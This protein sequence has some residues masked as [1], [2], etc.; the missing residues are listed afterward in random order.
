MQTRDEIRTQVQRDVR[1]AVQQAREAAREAARD[2]REA[3]REAR[4][5]A[6]AEANIAAQGGA[7]AVLAQTTPVDGNFMLEVLRGE[8]SSTRDFINALNARLEDTP[9]GPAHQVITRQIEQA[10]ER[11]NVLQSRLDGVL[12]GVSPELVTS[13][14]SSDFP[15]GLNGDTIR[16]IA[17]DAT[18]SAFVLI[19]ALAIGIPLIRAFSRW[20]DRRNQ[21]VPTGDFAH[22]L[23]RIEQAIDS[24]ALEVERV[25]ESQR[26][27][28][29]VLN[30]IRA[31]PAPDPMAAWPAAPA[32][33][34]ISVRTS[35]TE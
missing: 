19:F 25:S 35:T 14:E 20:L 33:E 26:Y 10:T 9:P 2:A 17:R 22:R 34:Q 27:N 28:A 12:T 29:R 13:T 15:P 1:E 7:A 16:E 5:E 18:R 30:E 8:L 3:A 4:A 32:R 11:L 6:A 24:V 23:D 21:P 31:L